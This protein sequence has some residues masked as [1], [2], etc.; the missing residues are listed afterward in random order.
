L[1]IRQLVA[2]AFHCE[3][4]E[5]PQAA[6]VALTRFLPS[7]A[8]R[9]FVRADEAV[10]LPA[11]TGEPRAGLGAWWW[12]CRPKDDAHRVSRAKRIDPR[13]SRLRAAELAKMAPVV[14]EHVRHGVS[15]LFR[16][17]QL[18]D[19]V[20]IGEHGAAPSPLSLVKRFAQPN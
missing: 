2:E 13:G 20:A 9:N 10:T 5:G 17:P 3:R 15:N 8:S 18:L 6:A 7:S 11:C 19:M 12:P 1:S 4:E 16:R 14:V